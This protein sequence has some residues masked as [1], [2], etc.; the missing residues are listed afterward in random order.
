MLNLPRP[1]VVPI[2]VVQHHQHMSYSKKSCWNFKDYENHFF[3][4]YVHCFSDK[5]LSILSCCRESG[6]YWEQEWSCNW[7]EK[8]KG[9]KWKVGAYTYYCTKCIVLAVRYAFCFTISRETC[10][11][12][13]FTVSPISISV[14]L[15]VSRTFPLAISHIMLH[16]GNFVFTLQHFQTSA[17]KV[18]LRMLSLHGT[19]CTCYK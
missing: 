11:K 4:K 1:S 16:F 15:L 10:C 6:F 2:P 12:I 7:S 14:S 9:F 18:S 17:H 3:H 8:C 5:A 19:P 13:D